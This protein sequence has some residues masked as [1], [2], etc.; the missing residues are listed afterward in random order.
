MIW[1]TILPIP[2]TSTNVASNAALQANAISGDGE[3]AGGLE[4]CVRPGRLVPERPQLVPE[5]VV[6]GRQAERTRGGQQI[7]HSG[8]QQQH[9]D[10][11][12]DHEPRDPDHAE[13][14]QLQP[15]PGLRSP[16][17]IR[18][19]AG[20]FGSRRVGRGRHVGAIGRP[21][22]ARVPATSL[23]GRAVPDRRSRA[24]DR[25]RG[26]RYTRRP[27]GTQLV[28]DAQRARGRR[29]RAPAPRRTVLRRARPACRPP[30]APA[31]RRPGCAWPAPR[32]AARARSPPP[33]APAAPPPPRRSPSRRRPRAAAPARPARAARARGRSSPAGA[34]PGRSQPALDIGV[35]VVGVVD[36]HEPLPFDGRHRRQHARIRR[37]R[38]PR[39]GAR[40]SAPARAT[41]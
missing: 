38:G 18:L 26:P 16:A 25:R 29:R 35:G 20:R 7:R 5:E 24:P 28:R 2:A 36:G 15:V 33:R 31:R 32:A 21:R 41:S 14:D 10:D 30:R 9:V 39:A 4:S 19:T 23:P 22:G 1:L 3:E 6:R 17:A 27:P 13:P 37:R 8:V 11:G 40:P 34:V 12:V